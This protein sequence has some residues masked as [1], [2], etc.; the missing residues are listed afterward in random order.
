MTAKVAADKLR[1]WREHPAVFVREVFKVEPDDW[2]EE[3]LEAFPHNQRIAMKASKG[4]GKTALLSWLIWNFLLT[5]PHPKVAATSITK[6]NLKDNLWSECAKWMN[7]SEILKAA[8]DWT[9]TRIAAKEHSETWWASARSWSKS[10]S[11]EEQAATLAGLHAEYVL[12]ILDESGGI[13]TAV[14]AMAEAA[15]STCKEGHIVQAGNPTHLEGPLYAACTSERRLWYIKEITGDP[16]DPKRAK[17]ISVQWAREQIEKYGRDNPFVRVNVFGQFPTASINALIGVEEVNAAMKRTYRQM[18]YAAQAMVLGID[19]ARMGDDA[20]VLFPRQGLQAFAPTV[21]RGL[22]GT[23]GAGAVARIWT[24]LDAD[25]CFIDDTGG[26]G[27]SWIDNLMRL[28]RAPIGVHFAASVVG[29][30]YANRRAEMAFQAVEWVKRGGA[31]PDC[32]E[33]LA[34]MT[35]TTYGFQGDKLLLE[36][37]DAIKTK[38]GYSPDHFD[39]LMLTFAMP[40]LRATRGPSG[41]QPRHEIDYD[42]LSRDR[43]LPGYGPQPDYR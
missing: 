2:Q 25:A 15:L 8:F 19:V 16:D 37:K 27:S 13:P 11:Q 31:L 9:Q 20:S 6:D 4:P 1:L 12:F 34:A 43:T 35:Q 3:V 17:R 40:V 33:L 42:P 5:R 36:P 18:E 24:D 21:W 39:A 26:F 30:R 23:Q 7:K 10:A 22:D 41:Q 32:P 14:M 28:G 29:G 38:L